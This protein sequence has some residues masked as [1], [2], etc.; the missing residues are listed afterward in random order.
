MNTFI[1]TATLQTAAIHAT[2]ISSADNVFAV[3][4]GGR[5]E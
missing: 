5:G 2:A 4:P 3:T 1:A